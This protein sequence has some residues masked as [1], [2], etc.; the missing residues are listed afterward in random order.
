MG[1]HSAIV[2]PYLT[3]YGTKE[4]QEKY[5]PAM[6]AGECIARSAINIITHENDDQGCVIFA[7]HTIGHKIKPPPALQWQSQTQGQTSRGFEQLQS[8]FEGL[9]WGIFG[10]NIFFQAWRRGL[11]HQRL[12][13]LHHKWVI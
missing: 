2:M 1:L 6:T 12:K 3:H 10:W 8:G 7:K 13:D 5:L 9:V 4:Q 11:D